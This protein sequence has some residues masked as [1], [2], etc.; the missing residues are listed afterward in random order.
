MISTIELKIIVVT[1]DDLRRIIR[2]E[3]AAAQAAADE[4]ITDFV[5]S[6]DQ[7]ND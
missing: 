7:S 1:E 5:D 2:E 6:L 4:A 3:I